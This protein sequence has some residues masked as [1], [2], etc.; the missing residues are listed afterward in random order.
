MSPKPRALPGPEDAILAD[1]AQGNR[2]A[3]THTIDN[4]RYQIATHRGNGTAD[5]IDLNGKR[6]ARST[7]PP[8]PP[9][10]ETST[11]LS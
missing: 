2:A 9:V 1:K 4:I 3:D 6:W 5:R 11:H 7:T 8:T 10:R